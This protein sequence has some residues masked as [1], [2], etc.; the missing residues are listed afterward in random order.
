M[1]ATPTETYDVELDA[2]WAYGPGILH[3]G[4]LLQ[5][6]ATV[7]VSGPKQVGPH[8]GPAHPDPLA[9]SG[10]YL[11]TPRL[12][13]AQLEVTRL[14][15]GRSVSTT[16]VSLIQ[17][18]RPCLDAVV[19]AGRLPD[20]GPATYQDGAPP[21]LPPVGDCVRNTT[22]P[23]ER[24]NGIIEQLEIMLDPLQAGWLGPPSTRAE[25]RAWVRHADGRDPDPLSLLCVADAL[26]PV[27]FA[28]GLRGWV[29]TIALTVHVRS[30][31]APGWLRVAHRATLIAD[32]M[33]DEACEI[34]DS[35]GA[36]VAQSTQLAMY[37]LS[38]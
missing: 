27:T 3:G 20:R 6:L 33:L 28:L 38:S 35:T 23:G 15:T 5:A 25:V 11:S 17:G 2:A 34:W 16:R 8:P 29:P 14:R 26:P 19:T 32:G 9:V 12:E 24:R 1:T 13:P 31:P 37:R 22:Q 18:G 4:Y 10:H 21:H 36:L 7:A 30:R